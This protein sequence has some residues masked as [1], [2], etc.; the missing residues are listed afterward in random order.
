MIVVWHETVRVDFDLS[1]R[2]VFNEP[3]EKEPVVFAFEEDRFLVVAAIVNV[4]EFVWGKILIAEGH[5]CV[6]G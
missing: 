2:H 5:V 1:G 3:P 4:V 6:P